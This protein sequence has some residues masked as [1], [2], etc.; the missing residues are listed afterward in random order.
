ME[1]PP[2]CATALIEMCIMLVSISGEPRS[3]SLEAYTSLPAQ[4]LIRK[5]GFLRMEM[6]F[7]R[8]HPELGHA[9]MRYPSGAMQRCD[10][11]PGPGRDAISIQGQAD[12]ISIRHGTE[13]ARSI[14]WGGSPSLRGSVHYHMEPMDLS[15]VTVDPNI[16]PLCTLSASI[17][18]RRGLVY[19]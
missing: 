14:L 12:A 2:N 9:E 5:S 18:H 1:T 13:T 11:H 3:Q 8:F 16:I 19:Y 6:G 7:P 15:R 4:R 17:F 10:I